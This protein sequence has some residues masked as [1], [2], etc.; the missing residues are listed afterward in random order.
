MRPY[1]SNDEQDS[2]GASYFL[3]PSLL[4]FF[5]VG[6]RVGRSG[7]KFPPWLP[8]PSVPI[9]QAHP[10]PLTSDHGHPIHALTFL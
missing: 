1:R 5:V 9:G 10:L 4:L 2:E 3:I 6:G 7:G 8:G